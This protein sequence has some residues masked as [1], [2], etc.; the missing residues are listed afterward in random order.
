[1]NPHLRLTAPMRMWFWD[2]PWKVTTYLMSL[3]LYFYVRKLN[4]LRIGQLEAQAYDTTLQNTMIICMYKRQLWL[5]D[6][7][8][9]DSLCV[10]IWHKTIKVM[11]HQ[12]QKQGSIP[13]I[14]WL[15]L[16][17]IT[18][19]NFEY[20]VCLEV[21]QFIIRIAY[22]LIRGGFWAEPFTRVEQGLRQVKEWMSNNLLNFNLTTYPTLIN[23]WSD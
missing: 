1:M 19:V 5:T 10:E 16:W 11:Y 8:T 2:L 21:S 18:Q 20:A 17:T 12:Q 15:L 4:K 14:Q 9:H 22:L 6:L 23:D 3:Y 7:A 13:H